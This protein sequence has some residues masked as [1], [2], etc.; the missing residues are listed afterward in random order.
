MLPLYAEIAP[1]GSVPFPWRQPGRTGIPRP[2]GPDCHPGINSNR[3]SGHPTPRSPGFSSPSPNPGSIGGETSRGP[4]SDSMPEFIPDPEKSRPTW[5]PWII[6]HDGHSGAINYMMLYVRVV[7]FFR[8][9]A[10]SQR[11]SNVFAVISI[12]SD[13]TGRMNWIG[14]KNR[15]NIALFS[16]LTAIHGFLSRTA[17]VHALTWILP[18]QVDKNSL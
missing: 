16:I 12:C 4:W 9:Q 7:H 10:F 2:G 1:G 17:T 6:R 18:G 14:R 5:D 8:L 3:G 13:S 15:Y 11:G